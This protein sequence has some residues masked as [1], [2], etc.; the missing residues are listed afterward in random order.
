MPKLRGGRRAADG[1]ESSVEVAA[2]T[3]ILPLSASTDAVPPVRPASAMFKSAIVSIWPAPKV[4]VSGGLPPTVKVMRLAGA[5][6]ALRQ[7]IGG[8]GGADRRPSSVSTAE[9]AGAIDR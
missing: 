3:V 1:D 5:D 9:R 7:Q 8:I 6:R 4:N 2:V